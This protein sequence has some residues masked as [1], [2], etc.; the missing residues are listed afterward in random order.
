MSLRI[1][2]LI[3][4]VI[5][6]RSRGVDDGAHHVEDASLLGQ[7]AA[8]QLAANPLDPLPVRGSRLPSGLQQQEEL[9]GRRLEHLV[10]DAG[11]MPS[12]VGL[13]QSVRRS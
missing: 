11:E 13:F 9:H 8:Q 5:G 4:L 7:A 12:E 3:G 10:Q 2:R 6:L 1:G